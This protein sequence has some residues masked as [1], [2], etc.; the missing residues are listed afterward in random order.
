MIANIYTKKVE[1]SLYFTRLCDISFKKISKK[2]GN[3]KLKQVT[4][5]TTVS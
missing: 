1:V 3:L 4:A 5:G 2:E